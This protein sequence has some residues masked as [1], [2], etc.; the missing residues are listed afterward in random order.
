MQSDIQI[1]KSFISIID[2]I[3]EDNEELNGDKYL[4]LISIGEDEELLKNIEKFG[5]KLKQKLT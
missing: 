3:S 2:K 1:C 4:A 5:V